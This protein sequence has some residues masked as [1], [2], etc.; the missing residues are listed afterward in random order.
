MGSICSIFPLYESR[1]SK[2]RIMKSTF[3]L[4][5]FVFCLIDASQAQTGT[6]RSG[7]HLLT[8]QWIGSENPGTIQFVSKG[9]GLYAVIGEQRGASGD[10]LAI[11]GIIQVKNSKELLFDGT[12]FSQV[13]FINNGKS[14]LREGKQTF[15]ATGTR[16]YW[17][18]QKMTN[19]EGGMV[20]DYIDIYF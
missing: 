4:S 1:I 17:R 11:D 8:L 12:I 6:V 9:K 19:C 5:L 7:K 2:F 18:L 15:K 3:Y 20:V 10:F 16:K 14:C 13:S